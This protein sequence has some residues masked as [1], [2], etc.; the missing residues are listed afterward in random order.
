MRFLADENFNNDI[1]RA[2]LRAYPDLD[3]VRVQDTPLVGADDP[4]LL[5]ET[6]RRGAVLLT[7]DVHTIVKYAYECVKSGLTMPG[8]IE[9]DNELPVGQAIDERIVIIGIGQPEDFD[10]QVHY[11]PM[12]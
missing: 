7:H 4:T 9:V 5:A 6:A 11:V 12:R 8:V 3:V 10:N 1:L 2:V